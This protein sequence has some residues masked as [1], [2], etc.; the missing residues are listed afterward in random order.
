MAE[1]RVL[2]A[3]R[4]E[5]DRDRSVSRD[6][7]PADAR[8]AG[9]A[10]VEGRDVVSLL[11]GESNRHG[12]GGRAA[13][14]NSRGGGRGESQTRGS[15]TTSAVRAARSDVR[16]ARHR[17][18]EAHLSGGGGARVG[19]LCHLGR[20]C[21]QSVRGDWTKGGLDA[22]AAG[23]RR[24]DSRSAFARGCV[25]TA[26]RADGGR[27]IPE[28][29]GGDSRVSGGHGRAIEGASESPARRF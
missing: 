24:A 16:R 3:D 9:T 19:A 17:G 23:D 13:D 14:G 18:A 4:S 22:R 5:V 27:E 21:F 2:V 25:G 10:L 12:D 28:Q 6:G 15:G 8:A 26:S 1:R 29:S 20:R 11:S 7:V